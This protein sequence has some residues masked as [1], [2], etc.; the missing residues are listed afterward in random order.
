MSNELSSI[1]K[2]NKPSYILGNLNRLF[3]NNKD[4]PDNINI[5]IQSSLIN[6]SGIYVR[7]RFYKKISKM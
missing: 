4:L 2:K 5:Q 3:K 7:N 1:I 6:Q